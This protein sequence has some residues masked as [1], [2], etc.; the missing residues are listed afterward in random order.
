[1]KRFILGFQRR[2]WC[3]KCTPASSISLIVTTAMPAS[4]LSM[5]VHVT[6]T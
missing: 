1:M 2:V 3:P 4:S 6:R 5:F